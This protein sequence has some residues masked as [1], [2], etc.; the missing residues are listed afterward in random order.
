MS[1]ASTPV[2]VSSALSNLP[3]PVL[4]ALGYYIATESDS[5]LN[6]ST[7]TTP[8]QTRKLVFHR[9]GAHGPSGCPCASWEDHVHKKRR[10]PDDDG[11]GGGGA[12]V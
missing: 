1:S 9:D 10:G 12:T 6:S 11:A 2:S 3:S 7:Q 5:D 8:K 4:G